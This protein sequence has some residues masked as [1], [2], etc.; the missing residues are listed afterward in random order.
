MM[1]TVINFYNAATQQLYVRLH[2]SIMDDDEKAE[3]CKSLNALPAASFNYNEEPKTC[4]L[5][6]F[7][8]FETTD[9][10]GVYFNINGDR[11]IYDLISRHERHPEYYI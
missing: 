2:P 6:Y 9:T 4:N 5:V 3:L 10:N 1:L 11:E 7:Q 8:E